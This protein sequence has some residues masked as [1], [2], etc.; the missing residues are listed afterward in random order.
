MKIDAV[1]VGCC[2]T[3]LYLTKICIASIR[4]WNDSI[5]VYLLRD[6]S[7][8]DFDTVD[9]E[10]A[11]NVY[12]HP[13]P[14]KKLGYYGKL[15]P[16][17]EEEKSRI[18]VIDSDIVWIRNII[19]ELEVF[20]E[21]I[22]MQCYTPGDP[23]KEINDWYFNADN[24]SKKYDDYQYPGF[25]FNGGEYVYS[26]SA[27]TKED[28]NDIITMKEKAVPLIDNIFTGE[29]QGILNYVLS[30][31]IKQ[32]TITYRCHTFYIW[33]YDTAI[34]EINISKNI[35]PNHFP[36]LVHWFGKKNGLISGMPGNKILSFYEKYYYSK[37]KNGKIK[38]VST[39]FVRTIKHPFAYM[40][41]I[42]KKVLRFNFL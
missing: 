22:I 41:I 7:Q 9:L 12:V 15:Y 34:N 37:I 17:I 36:P 18:L 16:F 4:Y 26:T 32:G 35:I 6:Y 5:P 29:D 19:P 1:Y 31:R 3:D 2:K 27:F 10:K 40:K 38:S 25:L 14:Y 11:L 28:F 39:R 42:I 24:L 13:M 8:G 20:S 21:D 33:G 30:K 23:K